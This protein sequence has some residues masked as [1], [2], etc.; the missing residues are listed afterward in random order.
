MMLFYTSTTNRVASKS[1][2]GTV[3]GMLAMAGFAGV[4]TGG[5]SAANAAP[6]PALE[7]IVDVQPFDVCLL[8]TSRH[9]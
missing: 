4:L 8:R 6:N 3:L 7:C 9:I 1:G 2:L 5:V